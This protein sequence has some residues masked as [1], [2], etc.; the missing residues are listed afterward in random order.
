MQL[1]PSLNPVSVIEGYQ[2]LKGFIQRLARANAIDV[3]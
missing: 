3:D 2:K 1:R